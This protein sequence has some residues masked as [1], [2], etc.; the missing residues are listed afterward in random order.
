MKSVFLFAAA[1]CA[2]AASPAAAQDGGIYLGVVGGFEGI[3]VESSDGTASADAD[4]SV[5]GVVVGYDIS[6]GQIF[7]GV[8]GEL[9]TS[10]NTATFPTGFGGARENLEN[11]GQY[12]VGAR[13]GLAI[14]PAIAA[15]G[16]VGYTSLDTR[17]FTSAGSLGELEENATGLRYG[18][19][20]QV[21]LP[22]PFE[23]RVEYRRSQY[24]EAGD[25]SF[26]DTT[27][28]QVVA[29]LGVRF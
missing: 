24:D 10:D 26:G 14:S 22:G 11:G 2:L 25:G 19:G 15:Y 3:E 27:T 23:A 7:A 18:G 12:Y 5:Y 16:K 28:D 4:S 9:S 20:L 1:A 8:E 17:A 6:L 29:G 21:Q 13:A